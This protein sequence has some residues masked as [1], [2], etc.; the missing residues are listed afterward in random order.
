MISGNDEREI[1][2]SRLVDECKNK[3]LECGKYFYRRFC[4]LR[5]LSRRELMAR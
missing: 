4:F 1:V 5:E 3:S 2:D